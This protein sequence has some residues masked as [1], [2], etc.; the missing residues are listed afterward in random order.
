MQPDMFL[1][2]F[3]SF[4]SKK[5]NNPELGNFRI[6]LY[7]KTQ[8]TKVKT[9]KRSLNSDFNHVKT[10]NSMTDC[11]CTKKWLPDISDIMIQL[12]AAHCFEITSTKTLPSAATVTSLCPRHILLYHHIL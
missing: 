10:V 6:I 11:K 12:F 5:F 7:I 9:D 8:I 2:Q 4:N 1:I 3:N